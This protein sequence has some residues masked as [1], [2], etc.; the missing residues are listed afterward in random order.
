M[1][2]G[3]NDLAAEVTRVIPFR[4]RTGKRRLD[5]LGGVEG[6]GFRFEAVSCTSVLAFLMTALRPVSWLSMGLSCLCKLTITSI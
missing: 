2:K 1:A 6:C 3:L 5:T 4:L